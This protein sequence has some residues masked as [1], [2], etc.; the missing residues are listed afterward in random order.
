MK[1]AVIMIICIVVLISTFTLFG[2][3]SIDTNGSFHTIEARFSVLQQRAE[4]L[5]N[6]N[7]TKIMTG[8]IA[9]FSNVANT[10]DNIPKFVNVITGNVRGWLD[11][12]YRGVAKGVSRVYGWFETIIEFL[13]P[14]A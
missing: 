10:W 13:I 1:S 11:P 7:G 9:T 14:G 4:I 6:E 12:L 2:N 8:V 3:D 5:I